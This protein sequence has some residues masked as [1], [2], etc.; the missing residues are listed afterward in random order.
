MGSMGSNKGLLTN[1]FH[2]G[3][4]ILSVNKQA[5]APPPRP[6][7]H[8]P[9]LFLMDNV[10]MGRIQTNTCPFY[11]IFQVLKVLFIKFVRYSHQIF[12]FLLF[13]LAFTSTDV[14]S[15]FSYIFRTSFN[16]MWKNIFVT[17]FPFLIDSFK[18]P[19]PWLNCQ[20]LISMTK[21]FCRCSLTVTVKL[22]NSCQ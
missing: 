7:T 9:S 20:N 12:Y 17:N 14:I 6:P 3:Q 16:I 5:H 2:H 4:K 22:K 19:T 10:K 11:I 21:V 13:L 18:A 1:N 15:V 8:T